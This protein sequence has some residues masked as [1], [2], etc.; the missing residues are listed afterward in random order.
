LDT[1][2]QKAL[3]YGFAGKGGN[4]L[5][6]FEIIKEGKPGGE[7]VIMKYRTRRG[8]DIFCLGAPLFY[9]SG[10]DWSLGPSWCYLVT[11][12]EADPDRYGQFN[13]SMC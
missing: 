11:W 5:N 13:S 8:T 1:N 6:K 9:D 2:R 3:Q 4:P 10:G 7:G 12:R